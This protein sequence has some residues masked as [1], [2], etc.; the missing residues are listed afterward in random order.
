MPKQLVP[1]T[2]AGGTWTEARFFGFIRSALR[3]SFMRYPPKHQ[4]KGNAK[5]VTDEG[6]RYKCADCAGLF[7]SG[8]VEVDHKIPC[9]SL[10]TFEDLPRFVENLYCEPDG[11]RVLCKP[12]HQV[13]TQASRKASKETK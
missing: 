7:K 11:L 9:G 13:R 1:R 12:C 5:Q 3:S 10:K 4:A 6:V 2:R 8:E